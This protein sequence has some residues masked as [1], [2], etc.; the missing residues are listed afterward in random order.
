MDSAMN[1]S[2]TREKVSTRHKP[3]SNV[4]TSGDGAPGSDTGHGGRVS[5]DDFFGT[6]ALEGTKEDSDPAD[7]WGDSEA[8]PDTIPPLPFTAYP[9]QR[10]LYRKA[11][12]AAYKY[13]DALMLVMIGVR[14]GIKR[15]K[16]AAEEAGGESR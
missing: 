7:V 9:P 16:E 11:F 13:P 6:P 3:R 5:Y 1:N 14:K 2:Q 15:G 10:G 4:P 12:R 8:E